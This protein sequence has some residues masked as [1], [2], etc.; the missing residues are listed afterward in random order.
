MYTES[1]RD[2]KD[3]GGK[4]KETEGDVLPN[5]IMETRP[6]LIHTDAP[7][8]CFLF[9]TRRHTSKDINQTI[10]VGTSGRKRN[11]G[12]KWRWVPGVRGGGVRGEG[13]E[14]KGGPGID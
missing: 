6:S 7:T 4:Q 2:L 13:G 1:Q 10:R 9:F 5:S 12:G 14:Q 8:P 3:T 11:G